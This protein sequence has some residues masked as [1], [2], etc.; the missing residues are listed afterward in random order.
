[1]TQS[2]KFWD[3]I[4]RKY[5]KQP[6]ADPA[7]YERKLS[8]TQAL[9]H[10]DMDVLE[11]GCGTGT[12]ALKHAP[13]VRHIRAVDVS[14]KMIDIAKDKAREVGVKNVTFDVAA[15]D[16]LAEPDARFDVIMAHSVLHLVDDHSAVIGDIHRM[17]KPGGYFISSTACLA[18]VAAMAVFRLIL[19]I[20]AALGLLPKVRFIKPQDMLRD[21]E[22]AGF[23]LL[24]HWQPKPSQALFIIAQKPEISN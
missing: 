17:L 15:I 23:S 5:S 16:D 2:A 21:V 14:P 18:G 1:M 11:I 20:G 7:S 12:T 6:V 13:F 3:K 19:P 22:T 8:E 9:L 10:P 4:A 24:R